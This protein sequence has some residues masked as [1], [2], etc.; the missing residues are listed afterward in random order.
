MD[1]HFSKYPDE[2]IPTVVQHASSGKV[3][4]LGFSSKQSLEK[5]KKS[6]IAHFFSR[7][8]KCLWQKGETSGD[9][10]RIVSIKHDCDDD[11]LLFLVI[12]D[13]NVCH[14]GK[15]TCFFTG[16]GGM[17]DAEI[18]WDVFSTILSRQ[19]SPVQD[20]YVHSLFLEGLDRIAQKVGEEAIETVIAS[21]NEN[22]E[23]FIGEASDLLFHLM[24]LLAEKKVSL[25]HISQ[26]FKERMGK[27]ISV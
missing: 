11:T 26:K 14:T 17:T 6:R 21:K 15:E 19:T 7:S 27:R 13:G 5:T 1:L 25:H 9:F 16:E 3:L 12:P 4:M 8:R 20:S 18:I 10:L 24:V 2:L 22:K 23:E